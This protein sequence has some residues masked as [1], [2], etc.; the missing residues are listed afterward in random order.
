MGGFFFAELVMHLRIPPDRF[1]RLKLWLR[2]DLTGTIRLV[3]DVEIPLK[4]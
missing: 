4:G 1:I 3:K 2:H